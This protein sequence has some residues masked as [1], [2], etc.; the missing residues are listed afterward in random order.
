MIQSHFKLLLILTFSVN[1][2]I[3]YNLLFS[4]IFLPNLAYVIQI[5]QL[6]YAK[7]S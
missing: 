7:M 3:F 1:T 6:T 4:F 2:F 5:D